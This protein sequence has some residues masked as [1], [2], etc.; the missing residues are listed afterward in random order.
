M[1]ILTTKELKKIINQTPNGGV[2]FA[3]YYDM[4]SW[5]GDILVTNGLTGATYIA[6]IDG[7]VCSV[8]WDIN[9]LG[10]KLFVLFEDSDILQMIQTLSKRLDIT[11]SFE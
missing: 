3:E 2:V 5:F 8:D 9:Q 4:E 1:K 11:L 7:E 6:P 10:A